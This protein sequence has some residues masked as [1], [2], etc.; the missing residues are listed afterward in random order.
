MAQNPAGAETLVKGIAFLGIF[1]YLK[2]QAQG[3]AWLGQVMDTLSPAAQQVCRR[4]LIAVGDYPYPVFINFL[5]TVDQVAGRGDLALCRHLGVL[6]ATRDIASVYNLYKRRASPADLLRDGPILWK[7]YYQ[8]AGRF[9][10]L[11]ASPEHTVMRILDFPQMDP[12]HCRLMEGWISQALVEGG[13]AWLEELREV[14]CVSKGDPY[15]E[16]VGRWKPPASA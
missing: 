16:F 6:A 7:S 14:R 1:K 4:K 13:A 3:E 5:R 11:D 10:T 15:H 12:A 9:Q 8:N 2:T